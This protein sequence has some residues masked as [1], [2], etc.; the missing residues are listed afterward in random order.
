M[1]LKKVN[2]IAH[3]VL[4]AAAIYNV[5]LYPLAIEMTNRDYINYFRM[6][7]GVSGSIFAA[8]VVVYA[9]TTAAIS[10]SK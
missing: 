3:N 5:L 1:Q 4:I 7:A 8:A 6:V 10:V 9:I 2:R